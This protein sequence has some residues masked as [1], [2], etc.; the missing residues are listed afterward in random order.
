MVRGQTGASPDQSKRS[1]AR[2]SASKG[3][4]ELTDSL[5]SLHGGE[6]SLRYSAEAFGN[7]LMIDTQQSKP[8]SKTSSNQRKI[9][10]YTGI[11][12]LR[13]QAQL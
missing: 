9:T 13:T 5:L 11:C 1:K 10:S 4:P 7:G 8:K 6:V 3:N 12:S 2:G